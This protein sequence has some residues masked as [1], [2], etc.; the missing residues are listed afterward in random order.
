MASAGT[1]PAVVPATAPTG[2]LNFKGKITS[3]P[4]T[5]PGADTKNLS[6]QKS[7]HPLL[8]PIEI[9][10]KHKELLFTMTDRNTKEIILNFLAEIGAEETSFYNLVANESPSQHEMM[11]FKNFI[12]WL[13]GKCENKYDLEHTPWLKELVTAPQKWN[14]RDHVVP[15]DDVQQFLNLL[16]D[17]KIRFIKQVVT[18]QNAFRGGLIPAYMYY[19]YVICMQ[20]LDKERASGNEGASILSDTWFGD[21]TYLTQYHLDNDY[22]FDQKVTQGYDPGDPS[23][24]WQ[25]L[26]GETRGDI[27]IERTVPIKKK[28][29]IRTGK[30]GGG[31]GK[32][33]SGGGDPGG[34]GGGAGGGKFKDAYDNKLDTI[35]E[36]NENIQKAKDEIETRKALVHL[37]KD[38]LFENAI[39]TELTS[40]DVLDKKLQDHLNMIKAEAV[41]GIVEGH[42]TSL[43]T[44]YKGLSGSYTRYNSLIKYID[45][46]KEELQNQ[47]KPPPKTK[48]KVDLSKVDLTKKPDLCDVANMEDYLTTQDKEVFFKEYNTNLA[49]YVNRDISELQAL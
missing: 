28:T 25:Y 32:G 14:I 8:T 49:E 36:M 12:L 7:F 6:F 27:D 35:R 18:L 43:D 45:D 26:S 3:N 30:V 20:T 42:I 9:D 31:A 29:I 2:V 21:L 39:T 41:K 13:D 5:S 37:I 46:K 4:F 10:M 17:A 24:A 40:L 38:P 23:N 15:G 11:F 1:D 34:G 19:K 44:V 48:P 47:K 33:D 16:V 22:K